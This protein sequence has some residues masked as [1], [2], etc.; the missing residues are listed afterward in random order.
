MGQPSEV[1]LIRD[2]R[3]KTGA[4]ILEC[5]KAIQESKGDTDKAL[6]LLREKGLARAE[7]KAI[8]TATDGVIGSYVHAGGR[9]G[10]LVELNCE[11]D[12]V[13]RT[14]DF[15]ELAKDV[16]MQ[17]AASNPSFVSR[18]EISASVVEEEKSIYRK[19]AAGSGKPE[20][21]V[22]KIAEGRMEKYFQ[23]VCLLDQPFIK[24]PGLSVSDRIK[25]S[26]AKLGEN[27]V[28]RRFVRFE[29]GESKRGA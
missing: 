29:L 25:Q 22:E 12:F 8:R 17:V 23:E 14:S 21:V 20:K 28:V 24:E 1:E 2:L 13:A 6:R 27:V 10:V 19:E 7:K 5:K 11:T 9:I 3:E 16:A 15:L 4:G 18:N 26:I